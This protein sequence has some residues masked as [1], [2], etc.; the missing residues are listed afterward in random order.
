MSKQIEDMQ[1]GDRRGIGSLF[2]YLPTGG[3]LCSMAEF[4]SKPTLGLKCASEI[5]TFKRKLEVFKRSSV[6]ISRFGPSG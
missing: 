5:E 3:R 6:F 1:Q 4:H 2:L